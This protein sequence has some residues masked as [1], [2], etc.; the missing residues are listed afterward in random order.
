MA[1]PGENTAWSL[2]DKI[3]GRPNPKELTNSDL[4]KEIRKINGGV[5]VEKEKQK[6]KKSK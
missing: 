3:A 2:K 1:K 4:K 6:I 5:K